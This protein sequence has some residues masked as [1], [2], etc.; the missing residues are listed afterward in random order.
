MSAKL[1]NDCKLAMMVS[2]SSLKGRLLTFATDTKTVLFWGLT[3]D[4]HIK[5]SLFLTTLEGS[6]RHLSSLYSPSMYPRIKI[7]LLGGI[8]TGSATLLLHTNIHDFY[9]G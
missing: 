9:L 2:L 1:P 8:E 7:S 5:S 6:N 3:I 4:L